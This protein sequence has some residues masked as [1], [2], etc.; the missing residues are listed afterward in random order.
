MIQLRDYQSDI[1]TA[2]RQSYRAGNNAPLVVLPTGGGKTALF[3]YVA[4]ATAGNGKTVWLIAHRAELVKQISMMLARF[5]C[6]HNIVAPNPIIRQIKISQWEESKLVYVDPRAS[7]HVCSA[8]TLVKRADKMP[9]PDLIIVDESHHMT[10]GSTWG[11]IVQA[12]PQAKLLAVTATPCRLDGKGLGSNH[13][14]FADDIIIGPSMSQL[15][16]AG[17]LSDYRVYAPPNNIDL[18]CI[19]KRAGDFAIDQVT[20]E[21]DKPAITGDAVEHYLKICNGKRAIVFCCTVDHANHVAGDFEAAGIP[22]ASIDGSMDAAARDKVLRDFAAGT[23]LVLTS[24]AIVSEGFDLPAI[25]AAILLRPTASLS[26]YLQQVGRA[27]RTYDGKEY[28]VILDHVGNVA[29][30]GFPDDDREWSLEGAQKKPRN[31]E[32]N[33][34]N[35]R[36]C[37]MCYAVHK[38]APICIQCGHKYTEKERAAMEV[39]EG[40]LIEITKEQREIMKKIAHRSRKKEEWDCKTESELAE[41]GRQRGY[42][43]ADAWAAKMWAIRSTKSARG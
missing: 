39:K 5:G 28:A 27:L 38:P 21:I 7:V 16:D 1:V 9:S 36:T 6:M 3:S 2:V 33:A 40:E 13:G 41:L 24:C 12:Q 34:V 4:N 15:I 8:Q 22:S 10:I 29:R 42:K 17:Y 30:H 31:S 23:I 43:F 26:L 18:S 32:G 19:K 11:N 14:G 35:V 25:E 20:K 37:P